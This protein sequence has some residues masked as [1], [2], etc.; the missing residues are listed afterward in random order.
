VK[1][2]GAVLLLALA[3]S[4]CATVEEMAFP[5]P[6]PPPT[7]TSALPPPEVPPPSPAPPV[8]PVPPPSPPVPAPP[9]RVPS[10]SPPAVAPPPP[11]PAPVLP[12]APP[13]PRVLSPLV[14]DEPLMRQEA[15]SRIDGTERIVRQIDQSKLGGDQQQNFLTIQSFL[16]KA[17]EALS[18]RDLQRAVNLADKAYV[19][20]DELS[21]ALSR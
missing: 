10:P 14:Q 15:Q 3:L 5:A 21:R 4:G 19:L 9:A 1:R 11:A 12:A 17:R 16:A 20:A 18:A 8:P 2:A 13:P 6:A 7:R